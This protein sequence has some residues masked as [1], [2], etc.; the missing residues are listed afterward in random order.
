VEAEHLG[1]AE[2]PDKPAA[3]EQPNAWLASKRSLSLRRRATASSPAMSQGCPQVHAHDA[4][5][6]RGDVALDFAR[7][8]IVR[9]GIDVAKD[10]R[11]FLPLH[12]V[13]RGDKGERRDDHLPFHLRPR[14]ASMRAMV[15]LQV[16]IQCFTPSRPAMRFQSRAPAGRHS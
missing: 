11:D 1:V 9:C 5:G 10:G 2:L 6:A 13:G 12:G 8:E 3:A 7:V 14:T 16:V 4:R 15:P